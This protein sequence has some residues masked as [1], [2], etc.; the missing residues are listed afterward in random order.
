M[1]H[2][3]VLLEQDDVELKVISVLNPA[4]LLPLPGETELEYDCLATIEQVYSSQVDIKDE[5]IDSAEM[6]LFVDG[7]SSVDNGTGK[8]GY[9]VILEKVIEAEALPSGTSAQKAELI[10]LIRALEIVAGKIA[11]IWT[12]SKYAFG[13]LHAHGAL[14]KE[15]GLLSAQ[16]TPVKYGN[17]IKKLLEVV[18]LPKQIA[19][20][21]CK[22]HQFRNSFI[23]AGSRKA[24]MTARQAAEKK[25]LRMWPERY[26]H[27]SQPPKYTER[28]DQL[29]K[30]LMSDKDENGW[31][32]TKD[33]RVILPEHL[34][35]DILEKTHEET[36]WGMEA[37]I[38]NTKTYALGVGMTSTAKSVVNKCEI[39]QKNNPQSKLRP[40]PGTIKEIHWGI[41]GKLIFLSFPGSSGTGICWY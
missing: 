37:L 34:L 35:R 41:I 21:H 1:K 38:D 11:N 32:M 24:D 18:Q 3:A 20:M 33:Q 5:P 17:V 29:A 36:H 19:V 4:T 15:R 40:P 28:D 27:L 16:G 7:S 31:W 14:W 10:A 39:C 30:L 6:N 25:I 9:A 26:Q 12:D 22:A 13:V 23:V 8:A 2:R